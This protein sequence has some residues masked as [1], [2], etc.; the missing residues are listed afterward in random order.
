VRK[1]FI[2]AKYVDHKF[3]RKTCTSSAAKTIELCEA[4]KSRDL[5]S[6]IQVYAEGVELMEPL[7]E[8]GQVSRTSDLIDPGLYYYRI[9]F[10][11]GP[12]S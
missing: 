2:N 12:Y 1:E 10:D 4:V 11:Q 3:A 7:P 6:L 8:G 9:S 5:L